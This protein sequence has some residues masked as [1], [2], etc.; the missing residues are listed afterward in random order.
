M[1]KAVRIM[2]DYSNLEEQSKIREKYKFQEENPFW[3]EEGISLSENDIERR[4]CTK[5][6]KEDLDKSIEQLGNLFADADFYWQLDGALNISLYRGEYIGVHKDIDLS[7]DFRDLEKIEPFLNQ[8]G[9]GLFLSSGSRPEKKRVFERI[10]ARR[11][12]NNIC[13]NTHR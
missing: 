5:K 10:D 1:Q 12:Q 8:K 4:L 3:E 6:E 11:L 9:F 13:N 7:I 2:S